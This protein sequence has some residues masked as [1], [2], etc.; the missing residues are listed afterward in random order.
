M[1]LAG[2]V[3]MTATLG[4][5][6][7]QTFVVQQNNGFQHLLKAGQLS[8]VQDEEQ[9]WMLDPVRISE[10]ESIQ[11]GAKG[12]VMMSISDITNHSVKVSVANNTDAPYYF[13]GIA[14]KD[15][16]DKYPTADELY[17]HDYQQWTTYAGYY[18]WL[19]LPEYLQE[20]GVIQ[21]NP[22]ENAISGSLRPNQEYWVYAFGSDA[23]GERLTPV[24]FQQFKTGP[25]VPVDVS[26]SL[27]AIVRG[28]NVELTVTPS[29]DDV[30]Y[31]R[32][33]VSDAELSIYGKS[34]VEEGIEAYVRDFVEFAGQ[35]TEEFQKN[36]CKK[37][38]QTHTWDYLSVNTQYHAFAV[39]V[40]AGMNFCSPITMEEVTTGSIV[41]SENNL[42][43][44]IASGTDN[45]FVHLQPSNTDRYIAILLTNDEVEGKSDAQ[46]LAYLESEK[47][48]S[49][50][51]LN[52]Q[53]GYNEPWTL[54]ANRSF[55]LKQGETYQAVVFGY[56]ME[57]LSMNA[58]GVVT[59]AIQ[60]VPF[61]IRETPLTAPEQDYVLSTETVPNDGIAGG[62]TPLDNSI[63]YFVGYCKAGDGVAEI[64]QQIEAKATKAGMTTAEYITS[65]SVTGSTEIYILLPDGPSMQMMEGMS[66]EILEMYGIYLA[67]PNVEYQLFAVSVNDDGEFMQEPHFSKAV[68]AQKDATSRKLQRRLLKTRP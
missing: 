36:M 65:K 66:E 25:V 2:M 46:L 59:T 55:E 18:S 20:Y 22:I 6:A 40:D 19:T 63:P 14:P 48:E 26:F 57:S 64:K 52:F 21:T 30:Y 51:Y 50:Y 29:D 34:S 37:G 60:R 47:F 3:A 9:Q 39:A 31:Y 67:E 53:N 4:I 17:Q 7:Q 61:S 62:F 27:T 5:Q 24:A 41:P 15:T 58:K 45:V 56:E 12:V 33:I 43:V 23:N 10:I 28:K 8:F 68:M 44:N 32:D 54:Q 49:P 35:G 13:A 42:Q 11:A 16:I 38:R 1:I